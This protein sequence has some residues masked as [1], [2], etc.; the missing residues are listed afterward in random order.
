MDIFS[1]LFAYT[2]LPRE[3]IPYPSATGEKQC[4]ICK[5]MPAI[6]LDA[7]FHD[8]A[9]TFCPTQVFTLMAQCRGYGKACSPH[10]SRGTAVTTPV[11]CH[12][13]V[14][15]DWGKWLWCFFPP[16]GF[17]RGP[18]ISLRHGALGKGRLNRSKSVGV[19]RTEDA[20]R[21]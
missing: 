5:Y 12:P 15:N 6:G 1:T 16:R 13:S 2:S 14:L 7:T 3:T 11:G 20:G 9:A 21:R 10:N 19:G 4:Q 8:E 18:R 17:S